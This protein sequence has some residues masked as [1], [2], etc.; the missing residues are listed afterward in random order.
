MEQF[1]SKGQPC[2][3]ASTLTKRYGWGVHL[4][5]EGKMA[6]YSAGSAEYEKFAKDKTLKVIK[7]MKSGK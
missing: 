3:R 7:A 4:N 1:F 5:E 2:F 6:I